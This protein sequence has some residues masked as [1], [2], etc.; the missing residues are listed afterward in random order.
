MYPSAGK[1]VLTI[2]EF[3]NK[4]R[5]T[6]LSERS[7]AQSHFIDLCTVLDQQTPVDADSEGNT[8]TFEKGVQKNSGGD[9]FADVWKRNYFA[10]EYKRKHENLAKAY[11]QLLKYRE[12]LENPPLL[13]VCDLDRF[14]VHTNWTNTPPEVYSF[15]LDDL[16][17]NRPTATCKVPPV[18]V[19]RFL[20]TDPDRLKPG[21]TTAQVTTQAA[22]EFSTLAEGLRD[23]GVPAERAAHFIMRLLFCL[24][25]EDIGLLPD[26]L[27]TRLIQ[28]NRRKPA[29]F[30]KKLRRLFAAMA[31][32]GG[33]F[34]PDDIPYFD[35]GLFMDDKAY[36]LTVDELGILARAADL[37]WGGIEPAIFGTLFERILDPDKR[38]QIG[39]HYTSKEDIVLIVEPV[40]MKPLRGEW[41]KVRA[42]ATRLLEVA[43][44]QKPQGVQ[45]ALSK[46]LGDFVAKIASVRVLD[47]A[48]GSGNF[49]YVALKLLLDLEK[50]VSV[51]ASSNQLSRFFVRCRPSQLYGIE[52]NIYAHKVASVS[53]WIGFLQWQRDNGIIITDNPIM[54]PLE[55]I[56]QMD[57]ILTSSA[58]DKGTEPDWPNAD[59]IV[60]NPPFLGDK[61][62]RQQL[63]DDYVEKLRSVYRGR[64]PGGSDLVC[65]WFEKAR[66]MVQTGRVQRAGLLATQ[67][68]RGGANR[69]VLDRIKKTGDIFWAESDRDWILDGAN[70]HVSMIAFDAGSET[71]KRLNGN[72]VAKINSDLTASDADLTQAQ[73]LSENNGIAFIGSQKGG[74]FDIS[75]ELATKML[76]QRG[77]PNGRPNSDVIKPW[78][79]ASDITGTSRGKW[80]ID[81]GTDMSQQEAAMYQ[82]PFEYVVKNIKAGRLKLADRDSSNDAWWLHQRPRPEMIE[83]LE[84]KTR[85]IA[86]PRHSKHRI[87][88]WLPKEV[89]PDSALVVIARDD[90]Y[91]LGVLHS[92]VHELWARRKGTQVRD[93]ESG[94]R[95]TPQ[96]TFETFPFPYT[97]G[98]EPRNDARVER[99][100]KAARELIKRRNLWLNPPGAS[101]EEL[102][103]RTLTKLYNE[104]PTW[105]QD[106]HQALDE[107]VILAYG[108]EGNL[109]DDE[110]L[111]RLLKLNGERFARQTNILFQTAEPEPKPRK[112]PSSV[113]PATGKERI[114]SS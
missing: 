69:S 79:N 60:G 9:G 88:M 1:L 12:A 90:D 100:A 5:N 39:A 97:P 72:E 48:C 22:K 63:G 26:R 70:V 23:R 37:N 58:R 82:A 73:S 76:Q 53:V 68:I 13:V 65:Y 113:R 96:S 14:E 80:I 50:Q 4:W 94:F 84:S 7:A 40:L 49:L 57:A 59:V 33:S 18:D 99:I 77:N 43:K 2:P 38:S 47:P 109:S 111:T 3:V 56:Q 98:N 114:P 102:R 78:A 11:Q 32:E 35:G 52:R 92:R 74:C 19:L 10:W 75:S 30:T 83:A 15:S 27:F 62:M 41:D 89:V 91:F 67:G 105:L 42:S 16:I 8:Y 95:Y 86:T 20:F 6:K 31:N 71:Q 64:I 104:E 34:G 29:E 25:S 61:K 28:N 103:N 101:A 66:A 87:F 17:E 54:Q 46:R 85:Y 93:A 21:Q 106:V 55:N 110:L 108:W 45:K 81:F 24:F 36:D 112:S 107:A 51:F 44:G